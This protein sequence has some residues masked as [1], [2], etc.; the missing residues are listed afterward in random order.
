LLLEDARLRE[1]WALVNSPWFKLYH[2]V[3]SQRPDVNLAAYASAARHAGGHAE[4]I[5]YVHSLCP[6]RGGRTAR[7]EWELAVEEHLRD[8]YRSVHGTQV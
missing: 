5:E 4:Q 8:T 7:T 6:P 3:Q 2:F 1:A